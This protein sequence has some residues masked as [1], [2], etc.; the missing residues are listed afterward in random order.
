MRPL[1]II[2]LVS[3]LSSGACTSAAGAGNNG[4]GGAHMA[5]TAGSGG[6]SDTAAGGTECDGGARCDPR[7]C[8]A[9]GHDCLGGA[10]VDAVC[11][12][13]AIT[14]GK[15]DAPL[16]L[17]A[18]FVYFSRW[19]NGHDC[20]VE[21]WRRIP[22]SGGAEAGLVRGGGLIDGAARDGAAFV[23]IDDCNDMK[24]HLASFAD[25]SSQETLVATWVSGE[26]VS[27]IA[28]G[29]K[30]LFV[31]VQA[32][33]SHRIDRVPSSGGAPAPVVEDVPWPQSLRSDGVNLYWDDVI[34][35]SPNAIYVVAASGGT[36]ATLVSSA[37]LG[38]GGVGSLFLD[39]SRLYFVA[40]ASGSQ[41][42]E[43]RWIATD[44][45]VDTHVLMKNDGSLGAVVGWND[46]VCA[47]DHTNERIVCVPKSGGAA[48]VV[49]HDLGDPLR[50]AADDEALYW[51]AVGSPEPGTSTL[52]RLAR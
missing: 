23:T 44:G 41:R 38:A 45:S 28:L 18:R 43:L 40:W 21:H 47:G 11:Q 39:S 29:P 36:P 17:D 32:E 13:V 46:E 37:S 14:S 48:R 19:T 26:M 1:Y 49:A 8:G 42:S 15:V 7:N 51:I 3:S 31:A 27:N 35:G 50:L 25:S 9:P 10:C 30:D 24:S 20:G 6:G 5:A 22:K 34:Q 16:V 4:A 12:P 33:T 52:Y 2:V